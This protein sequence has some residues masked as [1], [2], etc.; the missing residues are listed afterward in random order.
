MFK[1]LKQIL[2][3]LAVA[4]LLT[5]FLINKATY[6]PFIITKATV[7]RALVEVMFV[8][9]VFW[10][11]VKNKEKIY[12]TPLIKSVLLYGVVIFIS[13]L[14]GVNF[15]WSMFSGNERMEGVFGIWHF[16][17]FFIILATTFNFKE[18]EDLIKTQVYIGLFYSLLAIYSYLGLGMVDPTTTSNR[19]AGFTGN[20]SYFATYAL[21][22]AFFALYF[23][24]EKYQ[25]EKK[26][27][28]WWL[29]IFGIFSFLMFITGCRGTMIAFG[30]SILMIGLTI[31]FKKDKELL[32][33]KKLFSLLII[34]GLI[35]LGLVFSL[36]NTAFVKR[37]F[38]LER[39]TSIS[40]K[41]P[42]AVSRLYSA[43]TAFKGFLEKPLFGWG[44][45]NYQA[46][47]IKYFNPIVIRYLPQDFFFD[48]AHNKPMEVLT[49]TGIF[50]F[51]SYLSIFI[52][53]IYTLYQKQKKDQNWFILSS[54]LI[55]LIIAYFVQNIFIFDFH[56]S[57]LMFFL[58]LAFISSLAEPKIKL[59]EPQNKRNWP[60]DYTKDLLKIFLILGSFCLVIYSFIFLVVH[61]YV[62]SLNIIKGIKEIGQNNPEK[63]LVILKNTLKNPSFLKEDTII[64]YSRIIEAY[65]RGITNKEKLLEIIEILTKEADKLIKK[66]PERYLLIFNKAYLEGVVFDLGDTS[67]K[68]QA[69][70]TLK[71][72]IATAPY[73]PQPRVVYAKILL[74]NNQTEEAQ[75]QLEEVLKLNPKI[76]EA[77]Y[78]YYLILKAKGENEKA[79]EYLIKAIENNLRIMRKELIFTLVKEVLKIKRY[80]LVEKLYLQGLALDPKDVTFYTSL[81]VTYGKMHNKEKAIE[82]AKKAIEINP[83]I[84][85]AA[86][87]FI[88]IIENEEWDKIP[89]E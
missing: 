86:E 34:I 17:L 33:F 88:K 50:G 9:W 48:R 75:K 84:Q 59:S 3:Y 71:Q 26:I 78:F 62:V 38:A 89:D 41:D 52:M 83:N 29:V 30:L 76:A 77:N 36:K 27:F 2:F 85:Q 64:G 24:F 55:G 45:E 11:L 32:V 1:N 87:D 13:A 81:A 8:L 56:E 40:L 44:I 46:A 72:A 65:G 66:N 63:A 20:P 28:N 80:D 25:R 60:E 19:L 58:L 57:Y 47:Y 12:I 21:F 35:F 61:P 42:T 31:I 16:I 23:Y 51:I 10:L 22:N 70:E 37:F 74:A 73:F 18:I 6:F 54:V 43:K 68:Q 82:F 39:L 69:I 14:L 5:P 79:L 15:Y 53:A 67:K 49:T 7:F 4:C